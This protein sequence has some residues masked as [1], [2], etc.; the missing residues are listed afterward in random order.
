MEDTTHFEGRTEKSILN[1]L[2]N[3][4]RLPCI[5]PQG[6]IKAAKGEKTS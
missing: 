1:L 6:T 4:L 2:E 5:L 3:S